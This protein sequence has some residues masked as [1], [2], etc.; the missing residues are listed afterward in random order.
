MG[1]DFSYVSYPQDVP[2]RA[3]TY[4]VVR[5]HDP[6]YPENKGAWFMFAYPG[7]RIG[8]PERFCRLWEQGTENYQGENYRM[9]IHETAPIQIP[10]FYI[11]YAEGTL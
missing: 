5:I 2:I 4:P 7:L 1:I 10:V 8:L 3:G 6:L 9:I 11:R